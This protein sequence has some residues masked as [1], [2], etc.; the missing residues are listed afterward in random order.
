L[1]ERFGRMQEGVTYESWGVKGRQL[2]RLYGGLLTENIVQAV[3]RDLLLNGM[4]EAEKEGIPVVMTIH[5]EIVGEVPI[6]C[7][8]DHKKLLECMTRTP[9]W[10]EGMGFILAAEGDDSL[11]YKK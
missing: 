3:A 11:F 2:K 6:D 1:E 7:G 8:Y 9:E 10:A 5:D 4:L